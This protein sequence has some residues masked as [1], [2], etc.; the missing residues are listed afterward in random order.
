MDS[1]K[2]KESVLDTPKPQMDSTVWSVSETGEIRLTPLAEE[3]IQKIVN[4]AQNKYEFPQLSVFI[5]GSITSNSYSENSD[6]DVDFCCPFDGSKERITEFGWK[7][8]EDFLQNYA[9]S[10]SEDYMLGSHPFEIFFQPNPFQCM[11]SVG[12]YNFLEKKWEVGPELKKP[13][14]DP[15]SEYYPKGMKL[16]KS[17]IDDIRSIILDIYEQA[18]VMKKSSDERFLKQEEKELYKKLAEAG[19]IYK[20]MKKARSVYKQDPKSKEEALKMRSDK[21]WHVTD[22]SFKF[23]DKFGYVSILKQFCVYDD[24]KQAGEPLPLQQVLEEILDGIRTNI[25]NNKQLNDSEK[26]MFVEIE[27]PSKVKIWIDDIRQAPKNYLWLKKVDDFIEYVDNNGYENI[28]VIDIDHDAGDYQQ[29]GGDYI[30]CLDYLEFIGARD[31]NIRI[32]SANA[33]GIQNMRR[34]IKKN[35]WNEVFDLSESDG[36]FKLKATYPD[37]VECNCK[38]YGLCKRYDFKRFQCKHQ[39][40]RINGKWYNGADVDLTIRNIEED[41]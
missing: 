7:F 21:K 37:D 29:F 39:C 2:I 19:K 31:L 10:D 16:V 36:D 24:A 8:K 33:V 20:K 13:G 25:A 32:H 6:V 28:E 34:I 41:E 12:C 4:W 14:F 35:G 5:I 30:R 40:L 18:F 38:N 23:L 15:I 22:A 26:R 1:D 17:I 9:D 3:K 11:M 27:Q